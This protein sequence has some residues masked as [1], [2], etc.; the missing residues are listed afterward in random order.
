[1]LLHTFHE[2]TFMRNLALVCFALLM[3]GVFGMAADK[4]DEPKKIEV[5]GIL[6]T[7][8]VAPGGETTGIVVQAKDTTY[9]LDFGKDKELKAK[10]QKLNGKKVEASGT[11]RVK[12]GVEVKERRIITVTKLDAAKE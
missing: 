5:T 12:K 6:K 10:A 4:D 2:E 8:V 9:E 3:S 1:M 7:G 11:L